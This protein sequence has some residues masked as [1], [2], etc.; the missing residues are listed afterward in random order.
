MDALEALRRRHS[1]R[2]FDPAP[3]GR[4]EIEHIVDAGRL[5]ATAR[6]VQPWSFVAV[7]DAAARGRIAA[8]AEYGKFIADAP[9]CVAVLCEDTTYY[10]E[11]GSAAV[12]NML[13]AAE[14]LGIAS[15]WVAGDK[16]PYAAELVRLLGAPP[17]LRLVALVALGRA[18]GTASRAP[19]KPLAEVL[20]WERFGGGL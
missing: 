6:N 5:A 13:V 16:K 8:M 14:A 17:S 10:L 12:Q 4:A 19:K 11:D 20:H 18:R 9:V 15:C 1:T 3:L 2:Q 7:T